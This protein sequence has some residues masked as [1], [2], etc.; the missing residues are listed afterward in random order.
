LEISNVSLSGLGYTTNETNY[1]N[2]PNRATY[3]LKNHDIVIS[4]V[5][6]NRNAVAL[7]RHSKRLVGTSGFTVLRMD[8]LSPYYVFAFCKT[9]YFI[10]NLMRE[11]TATMYPAVSDSDVF[12]TR[13]LIPSSTFQAKIEDIVK[14]AY[15]NVDKSK[16][17]ICREYRYTF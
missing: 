5:R 9:K 2:I 11:N 4:T 1:L 8:K 3:V 12:K 13:I 15:H 6:P 10:T 16:T 7:I 14:L 17:T